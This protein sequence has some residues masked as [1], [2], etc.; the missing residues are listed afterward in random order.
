MSAYEI[1]TLILQGSVAFAAFKVLFVYK[2]QLKVMSA[3]LISMQETSKAQSELALADFLQESEVR[4]SRQI[5]RKDLSKKPMEEWSD[6]EKNHASNVTANYDVVGALIKSGIAP[7]DLVA[8]NWGP[9][10]IHCYKVLEPWIEFQ[11]NQ[12]GAHPK[13][14]SNFKWLYEEAKKTC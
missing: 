7:V 12:S 3:Q 4:K 2:D 1:L 13:Y 10:I 14:W 9:S 8:A 6:E 5:V 11:R